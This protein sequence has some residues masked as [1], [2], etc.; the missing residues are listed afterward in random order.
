MLKHKHNDRQTGFTLIEV[1]IT[2]LVGGIVLAVGL[3]SFADFTKSNRLAAQTNSV[4]TAL[5]LA[6]SEAVNR[7]HNMRVLPIAASTDW[8]QGWQVRLDVDND[9]TTD[10]EDTVLRNYDAIKK[11]TLVGDADNVTYQSSG[12]ITTTSAN[13]ITLTASECTAED[14]RVISVKLSGLVSSARQACPP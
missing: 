9:G 10:A 14:I 6:R 4:L 2:I 13:T 3:P 1:M 8:A 11:A 5:H 7:G 12:F